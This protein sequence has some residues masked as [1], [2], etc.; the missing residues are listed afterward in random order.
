MNRLIFGLSLACIPVILA[1]P[2]PGSLQTNIGESEP[3]TSFTLQAS[4][5]PVVV[6]QYTTLTATLTGAYGTPAGTVEFYVSTTTDGCSLSSVIGTVEGELGSYTENYTPSQTG[7]I[8]ICAFYIPSDGDVYAAQTAPLYLLNVTPSPYFYSFTLQGFPNPVAVGQTTTLTASLSG[9]NGVPTGQIQFFVS[10]N[11]DGCSSSSPGTLIG[12]PAQVS[13]NT[14]SA[15][16]NWIPTQ[17]G[18]ASICAAYIPNPNGDTYIAQISGIY[19]LTVGDS[20]SVFDIGASPSPVGVGNYTTLTAFLSGNYGAA[21]GNVEFY[22]SSNTNNTCSPYNSYNYFFGET[23]V[24]GNGVATTNGYAYQSGTLPICAA[25]I[26]NPYYDVYGS[27]ISGPYSLTVYYPT[28][29]TVSVPA[30]GLQGVPVTFNFGLTTPSGQPAP[31]G[32]ITLTDACNNTFGPATVTGLSTTYSLQAA[33]CGNQFTATYSGDNNYASQQVG[34]SNANTLLIENGLDI[35]GPGAV[36]PDASTTTT[37]TLTGPGITANS[38]VSVQGLSEPITPTSFNLSAPIPQLTFTFPNTLGTGETNLSLVVPADTN[39]GYSVIGGPIQLQVYNLYSDT[40]TSST[41]PATVSYGS[42]LTATVTRGLAAD[43]AVPA[44]PVSFTLNGTG[45]D[46]GYSASLGTGQLSQLSTQQGSYPG[47]PFSDQIDSNGTAKLLSADLN[48]DGYTDVV[49]IPG[50][51]YPNSFGAYWTASGPYLQVMLS[52]GANGLETEEQV[53]AGCVPQDFAVGDITGDGI[54]DLVVVCNNSVTGAVNNLVAYYMPG[55]ANTNGSGLGTGTFGPPIAFG[56]NSTIAAPTNVV[57]GQFNSDGYLDIA[58]ID[59]IKGIVQVISPFGNP[60]NSYGPYVNFDTSYGYVQNAGAADFNKDNFS[61]LVL[62]EYSYPNNPYYT[63]N[64]AVLVLLSQGNDYGFQLKSETPFTA[65]TYYMQGMTVTDVNGDGYP[66]V[67]I[68]DYGQPNYTNY[69]AGN[70]LI[71]ENDQLGDLPLTFTYSSSNDPVISNPGTVA[72]APFPSLLQ[73]SS[74][75]AAAPG[76]NL[77]YTGIGNSNGNVWVEELQR[78]GP[79]NW[80]VVNSFDTGIS[81]YYYNCGECDGSAYLPS[82]IVTGDLNGDG[83]LD[84][85]LTGV[86]YNPNCSDC[87]Q[88]NELQSWY[89]GNDA[90]ANIP[91]S[92]LTPPPPPGTYSLSVNYPGNQLYQGGSAAAALPITIV[93]GSVSGLVSGP[94]SD[95]F[96]NNDTFTVTVNGAPGGAAPTGTVVV[97]S[98]G[99]SIG[100]ANL[101][102]DGGSTATGSVTTS[103]PLALGTD[104]ITAFYQG[105]GNYSPVYLTPT[106]IQISAS[107]P[108]TNYPLTSFDIGATPAPVGVGLYTTLTATLTGNYGVPTGQVRF[109]TPNGS[110]TCAQA[111]NDYGY[112][113]GTVPVGPNG[114]ATSSAYGGQAGTLAICALYIPNQS[115]DP[116]AANITAGPYLLTVNEPTVFSVSVGAAGLQGT[117]I[118]FT[119]G[120]TTP[121][122]QPAPT[123]T[124]TLEDSNNGYTTIGT[125]SVVDGVVTPATICATLSGSIYYAVYSGDNNYESQSISGTVLIANALNSIT[126]AVIPAGSPDTTFTLNGQGFTA[127]ST[128]YIGAGDARASLAIVSQSSTQLQVTIPASYLQSPGELQVGETTLIGDANVAGGPV[129]LQ[130]FAPYTDTGGVST[131]N[132][133][134]IPYGSTISTNFNASVTRGVPS[135][136]AAVPA[137]QVTFSLNGTG[138]QSGYSAQLGSAQLSQVT[139]PGAYLSPF[140]EPIDSNGNAKLISADLNGDGF[141]DVVGMPGD[142]YPNAY[143]EDYAA[144]PYLQVMLSTGAN[145]LQTEQQV[146]T[147]CLAQDFAVGDV[148]GDGIPDLVVVCASGGNGSSSVT[149]LVAYYMLGNGDGTFQAPVQFG[150]NSFVGSP[151]NVTLGQFNGDGYIDIAV[152]D[153]IDGYLQVISPF[154]NPGNPLGPQVGFDTSNGYVQTAGAADFNQDGLSDIV[155]EEY[156]YPNNQ[157]QYSNGAVL[158]LLSQGNDNGFDTKSETQFSADTWYMQSMTVTDVNGDGYPDV[159]IADYG[160]PYSDGGDNGAVLVFE[161]DQSGDLPLT[162]T[163]SSNNDPVISYP[164]AVV[165]A[166]FPTIGQ[167][168]QGAAVAPGWNLVYT[169]IGNSDGNVWVEELQRQGPQSWTVVNSYDTGVGSNGNEGGP[170]PGLL[171]TGDMN[172]DG[173]LDFAVN[174]L[175]YNSDC[176]D[177]QPTYNL[178]P[179]YYSNDAQASTNGS[180][181][182]PMPSPGT[183]SL[184]MTYPGNQLY[185]PSPLAPIWDACHIH[186]NRCRRFGRCWANGLC[187]LL[188]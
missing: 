32:T 183:Y 125:A 17:T 141:V 145:G 65:D 178:Q 160:Q 158:V 82:L 66:D 133:T 43:A 98:N 31:T 91:S 4:S 162:F 61:D 103:T 33:P 84:F 185:Q 173:Y 67:V 72:G 105:D 71:F 15:S 57:L 40:V 138:A 77:V 14:G 93:P 172:G 155:L 144:G 119:F 117:P 90:Q 146:Y 140:T 6:G 7:A 180:S 171:V 169:G 60:G 50:Q 78:Q 112:D 157:Y 20:F 41:T 161:N 45:V 37:F 2:S 170:I 108:A 19:Q 167:P 163:Y 150:G 34:S 80:T 110:I 131:A 63:T 8:P 27:A 83:Y 79:Q 26:P 73:P 85:A 76:W 51:Y 107:A 136:D 86:P 154:G 96:G 122:G 175:T 126:P 151:T 10:S 3:F 75:A 5:N 148:N 113:Y 70:L 25:Y 52:T 130:V 134:S 132:P 142:Y 9:S 137:G 129:Q 101:S 187:L 12:Q 56:G 156:T 179:W 139:T 186:G 35:I 69:D 49:G 123:G 176:G 116:Y 24:G 42:P 89:Y 47:P 53:Y 147:G 128:A 152:I 121:S 28:V 62:E 88:T 111:I 81:P 164:N 18:P 39:S 127:N 87:S 38:L 100:T 22:V 115:G 182:S 21:P 118:M 64:G 181:M 104:T 106:N 74:T 36:T 168:A 153:G 124:I 55:I 46:A 102:S 135:V 13:S 177:C 23:Q 59:G 184:S 29:L 11:V 109:Y 95:I 120:I 99:I 44:G 92:S 48:G 114:V 30:A 94:S 58:V 159:A 68:T 174:S 188:R 54:P 165:G 143:Y 1:L 97:Y 149:N 166:P 16:L